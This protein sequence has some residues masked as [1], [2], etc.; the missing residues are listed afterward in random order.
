MDLE[1][2]KRLTDVENR[3]KSNT[4]RLDKHEKMIEAINKLATSVEVMA[5][6]QQTMADTLDGLAGKVET[7]EDK[8][9][10]RWEAISEKIIIIIVSAIVGAA[11]AH[12]GL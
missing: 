12:F 3:A 1:H 5:T 10:K 4:K 6:K 9:A 2:E 7:I 11:L 8:P